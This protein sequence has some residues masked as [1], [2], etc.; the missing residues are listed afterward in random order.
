[1]KYK[2]KDI[3]NLHNSKLCVRFI[4]DT[5]KSKIMCIIKIDI[6]EA[7]TDKINI[8]G[9]YTYTINM[10]TPKSE[11]GRF[12]TDMTKSFLRQYFIKDFILLG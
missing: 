3:N 10:T 2:R 7:T 9:K 6:I 11:N 1:M 8:N 12:W 5:L 4:D